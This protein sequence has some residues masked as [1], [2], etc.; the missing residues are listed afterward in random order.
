MN[1]KQSNASIC[2]FVDN[3]HSSMVLNLNNLNKTIQKPIA[4]GQLFLCDRIGTT[5][6]PL[7]SEHTKPLYTRQNGSV[8]C[9][10]LI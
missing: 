3:Q 8:E 10:L 4:E 1:E 6:C 7:D 5:T 9:N 2:I